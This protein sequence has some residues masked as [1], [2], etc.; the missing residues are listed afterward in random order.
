MVSLSEY[1]CGE[2]LSSTQLMQIHFDFDDVDSHLHGLLQ[3][4]YAWGTGTIATTK[5][6]LE[7]VPDSVGKQS[8]RR[9]PIVQPFRRLSY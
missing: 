2:A 1:A 7:I 9:S 6:N 3:G 5:M 8:V 4:P